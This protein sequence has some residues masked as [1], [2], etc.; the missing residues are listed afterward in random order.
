MIR[1]PYIPSDRT[2]SEENRS[3]LRD[4]TPFLVENKHSVIKISEGVKP[5]LVDI[6]STLGHDPIIEPSEKQKME[7]AMK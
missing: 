6:I 4:L 1:V 5:F 3:G 7:D 2:Y